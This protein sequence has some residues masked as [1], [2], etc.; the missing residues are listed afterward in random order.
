LST[1][2]GN[3]HHRHLSRDLTWRIVLAYCLVLFLMQRTFYV[4]VVIFA[5]T[6]KRRLIS[7]KVLDDSLRRLVSAYQSF[8][9][10]VFSRYQNYLIAEYQ[11]KDDLVSV[12]FESDTWKIHRPEARSDLRK[13]AMV[14]LLH[15]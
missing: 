13:K 8:I 1:F 4:L 9:L 7:A 14:F 15:E 6:E 10:S 12:Q 5:L 11:C 2:N 3:L